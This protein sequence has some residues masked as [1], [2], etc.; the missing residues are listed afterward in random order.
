MHY[1]R[2]EVDQP[3]RN[4]LRHRNYLMCSSSS[5]S[6]AY[7]R[8]GWSTPPSSSSRPPSSSGSYFWA[9]RRT[10]CSGTIICGCIIRWVVRV[11]RSECA[12]TVFGKVLND[13]GESMMTLKKMEAVPTK[14][15]ANQPRVPLRIVQCGELWD[16]QIFRVQKGCYTINAQ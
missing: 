12:I 15:G 14:G 1:C 7:E 3:H 8:R 13:D 9:C 6:D 2:W 16:D 10:G 4:Y 5:S 11:A